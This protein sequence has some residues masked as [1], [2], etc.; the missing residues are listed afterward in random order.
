MRK[1]F[2]GLSSVE[3]Y[4]DFFRQI[5][6]QNQKRSRTQR[7]KHYRNPL[8]WNF[9]KQIG[10][11]ICL[12]EKIFL[13]LNSKYRIVA[14]AIRLIILE[15]IFHH[16]E[17][18]WIIVNERVNM[19]VN[20]LIFF[21]VLPLARLDIFVWNWFS[22]RHNCHIS[23]SFEIYEWRIWSIWKG[24]LYSRFQLCHI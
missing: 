6:G 3:H 4:W 10:D 7:W 19:W 17:N 24:W 2:V 23:H 11:E 15:R 21:W 13:W 20:Q 8:S 12:D 9:F 14:K 5:A 16:G 22:H 18:R 1:C